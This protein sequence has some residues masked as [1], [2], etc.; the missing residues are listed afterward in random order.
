MVVCLCIEK[1]Q[2]MQRKVKSDQTELDIPF[3]Q[4]FGYP[5][6]LDLDLAI[7]KMTCLMWGEFGK[8]INI[9]LLRDNL[10]QDKKFSD[11]VNP[12][13]YKSPF[14]GLNLN[15]KT[16]EDEIIDIEE[17][18]ILSYK[19][20]EFF[21][22]S[23]KFKKNSNK[24]LKVPYSMIEPLMMF[25]IQGHL[26]LEYMHDKIHNQTEQYF[27]EKSNAERLTA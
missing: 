13:L 5:S 14:V 22:E 21:E 3:D 4:N 25:G 27:R 17:S 23:K 20:L 2:I 8:S 1:R 15:S 12:V 10:I 26:T 6:K 18:L 19:L 7:E 16:F 24:N 11:I 9:Q